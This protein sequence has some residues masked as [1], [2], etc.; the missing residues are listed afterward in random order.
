[1]I[2]EQVEALKQ[3][4]GECLA[5]MSHSHVSP[6]ARRKIEA[7]FDRAALTAAGVKPRV[8]PVAYRCT[9]IEP[10]LPPHYEPIVKFTTDSE[11]AEMRA[12]RTGEWK[13]E[14]LY[15]LSATEGE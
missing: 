9:E 14:P 8:K 6:F 5:G 11:L 1:M 2:D 7:A 10:L 15:L 12:K 13:V 4:I 3:S